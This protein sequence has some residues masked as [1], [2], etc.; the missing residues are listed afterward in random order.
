MEAQFANSGIINNLTKFNNLTIVG[1]IESDI[2]SS[3]SNIVLRPPA[4]NPYDILKERLIKQFSESNSKKINTLLQDLQLGDMKPSNL[5]QKMCEL[6]CDKVG[7]ALLQ[8][9][10]IQRLPST[11]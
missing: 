8:E 9:L 2:L 6:S 10:W 5:L 4:N 3:V 7:D 11:M 1:V